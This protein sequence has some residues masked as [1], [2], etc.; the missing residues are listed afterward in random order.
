[1]NADDEKNIK[2]YESLVTKY[3]INYRSLDWGSR[4]SQIERFKILADIGL[5]DG[6]HLL[7]V[8]CGLGDLHDW[9]QNNRPGVIYSGIDITAAMTAKASERFPD[10]AISTNTIFTLDTSCCSY[11]YIFASG[12]FV[13]RE[14]DPEK[15]L[16]STIE[17]MFEI[18]KKG[19]AFN[20]LSSWLPNKDIGEF[21]ADPTR[22]VEYCKSLSPWVVMRHDYHPSDFT[23]YLYKKSPDFP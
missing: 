2:L 22:V 9:L 4:E 23:I 18:C 10:V 8:G 12:I 1:M 3:G 16:F 11:D 13:F 5:G 19:I 15:Y 14:I 6:D 20:C 7:D 21:R 17:K